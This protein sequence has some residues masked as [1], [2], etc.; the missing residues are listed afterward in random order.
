MEKP[1][2]PVIQSAIA[3]TIDIISHKEEMLKIQDKIHESL[4]ID[5]SFTTRQINVIKWFSMYM[6]RMHE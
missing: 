3:E 2:D 5:V 6:Y 1:F 4:R